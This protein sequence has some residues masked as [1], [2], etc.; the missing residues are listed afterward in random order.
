[1]KELFSLFPEVINPSNYRFNLTGLASS[2]VVLYCIS[3]AVF[4][5]SRNRKLTGFS[6]FAIAFPVAMWNFTIAMGNFA[7][8]IHVTYFY[9]R[10]TYFFVFLIPPASLFISLTL[11]NMI[12]LKRERIILVLSYIVMFFFSLL[13]LATDKIMKFP[14]LKYSWGMDGNAG[15]WLFYLL[16]PWAGL[17]VKATWNMAVTYRKT[18]SILEK[19]KFRILL[20]GYFIGYLAAEDYLGELG[21][22]VY[23]FGY[24][25]TCI[26]MTI[27]VY[28]IVRFKVFEFETIIHKTVMWFLVSAT[29]F[30]PLI[31]VVHLTRPL[32]SRMH[33]FSLSLF[34]L[35]FFFLFRFYQS[36]IQPYI[37]MLFRR[38]KYDYAQILSMLSRSLKGLLDLKTIS[39]TVMTGLQKA[40]DA[41]S[42]GIAL[43]DPREGFLTLVR[44]GLTR[45]VPFL[46]P[47][48]GII[49]HITE[50]RYFETELAELDP[51]M[52]SLKRSSLYPYC[53]E[54]NIA[55]VL[56]LQMEKDFLGLILLG[57]KQR[58]KSYT[59]KDIDIL[60]SLASNLA[61]YFYNAL[62][63]K[64][65]MENQ[66]MQQELKLGHDIQTNLLPR[67][68]PDLPGLAVSGMMVP[69]REIG[70]DYYDYI[71]IRENGGGGREGKMGIVI[72]DVSGK[73]LSAGLIMATAKATLKGLSREN[74][75]PRQILA[76]T[77]SLLFEYTNGEKYMT[78]LYFLYDIRDGKLVY[79][80]AAH[81]HILVYHPDNGKMDVIPAGG[82]ALGLLGDSSGR[83]EDRELILDRGDK[84]VLY[85]DGVIDAR[86]SQKDPFS[87]E[88]LLES[89]RRH[90]RRPAQELLHGLKE[91]VFGFMDSGEQY[92]DITFVVMERT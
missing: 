65:I 77:N 57:R 27:V 38:R 42:V 76:R 39:Q 49:A 78:M 70:G 35:L 51:G 82:F 59:V 85:T 79:S 48:D 37:D 81:E 62:H 50:N 74:L 20:L 16:I 52:A 18:K 29:V 69:A 73:G 72:G 44:D 83:L 61:L 36:R 21:I 4:V 40:L 23:P 55:L 25:T 11:T 47:E 87:M 84:V 7:A 56:G 28:S 15:D 12:A 88:R 2:F 24:L 66:R 32:L 58:V 92:D 71:F 45:P 75:S 6:F 80:S 90:G 63:H 3:L 91:D 53:K 5:W 26:L 41:G 13:S 8:N 33:T 34:Y 30:L 64:D 89:V 68:S 67:Q 54:E 60:T 86:N 17:A 22:P 43:K 10:F 19:N 1:M 9:Y 31:L 14:P 46:P